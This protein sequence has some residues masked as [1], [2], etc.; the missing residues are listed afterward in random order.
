MLARVD[1]LCRLVVIA[2][3]LCVLDAW[4]SAGHERIARIA[5]GLLAG[6]HRDQVR[7]LMHSDVID[8]A[9]WEEV[10]TKAH[11]ETSVLHWHRQDPEWTCG[12]EGGLGDKGGHVRCDGHGAEKGSLFCALAYFFEH[13]AHDALL[14][15]FPAPKEPIGTPE[16]LPTL[17]KIPMLELHPAAY[18]RWLAIL[19][20]DL[21]QPLHWL[22][23]HSHGADIKV[24]YKDSEYTLLQFW[25][26]YLPKHLHEARKDNDKEYK[27]LAKDWAH[28]VPTE[29]FRDWAKE[30]AEKVCVEVYKPM[31]VNHASG[32]VVENPFTLPDELFDKWVALAEELMSLGGERLAFVLNEIIEHKR[33]KE[34]HLNGRGHTGRTGKA[35][36]KTAS[37]EVPFDLQKLYEQLEAEQRKRMR[38]DG[39]CNFLI[40]LVVVPLLLAGFR[41]HERAAVGLAMSMRRKHQKH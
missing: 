17:E 30:I 34:A 8:V 6:K 12:G 10:E 9:N 21:H 35:T 15:D 1:V 41:W 31:T 27:R 13:F 7:T 24:R 32:T 26:E 22:H 29:L 37:K 2:A 28:K 25:E 11:P 14:K 18:L 5:Q 16:K 23:E 36:D 39:G 33:H 4:S 3:E 40:A 20:G 19:V 38:Q